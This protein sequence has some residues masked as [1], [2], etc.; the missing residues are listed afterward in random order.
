M[1][2]TSDRGQHPSRFLAPNT[3]NE[4]LRLKRS[5]V[6]QLFSQDG[7]FWDAI[8]RL[9]SEWHV[10]AVRLLPP[11]NLGLFHPEDLGRKPEEWGDR[12]DAVES[13]EE[14]RSQWKL[15]DDEDDLDKYQEWERD[16]EATVKAT[17]PHRFAVPDVSQDWSRFVATCALCDPPETE[18]LEFA[19]WGGPFALNLP[20]DD[21]DDD[22]TI[23]SFLLPLSSGTRKWGG[24]HEKLMTENWLLKRLVREVEERYLKPKGLDAQDVLRDIVRGKP[25]IVTEVLEDVAA[26]RGSRRYISV[27]ELTNEDD[28]R[29]AYRAIA[30]ERRNSRKGAPRRDPLVAIQCALLHDRHNGP[31][32]GDK[33]R[34]KWTY[35]SLSK[36]FG[37]KG[38]LAAKIHIAEGREVLAGMRKRGVLAD[39]NRGD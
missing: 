26:T 13:L 27:D 29:R 25:N 32:P 2:D 33:R 17:I 34:S 39:E 23:A 9:R 7:V 28:V 8:R 5:L 4:V 12:K 3:R 35:E 38:S 30:A 11:P 36:E 20:L 15:L 10:D 24:A 37:L 19:D 1:S 6:A 31:V 14:Y 16:L 22:S 18:L 21:A